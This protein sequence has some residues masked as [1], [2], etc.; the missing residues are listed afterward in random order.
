[1]AFSREARGQETA[2]R[3]EWNIHR[4]RPAREA[5]PM[6]I[7]EI[8]ASRAA[9]NAS[10][11]PESESSS[12]PPRRPERPPL[13]VPD[14]KSERLS[15]AASRVTAMTRR[16]SRSFGRLGGS[17]A[18][19][20][21]RE[22]EHRTRTG[23]ST[24]IGSSIR[25]RKFLMPGLRRSERETFTGIGT[26]ER[27]T[28]PEKTAPRVREPRIFRMGPEARFPEFREGFIPDV[29][30]RARVLGIAGERLP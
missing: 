20:V 12:G 21:Q 8:S 7:A 17:W 28:T 2:A 3:M 13:C 15:S 14:P 23:S 26:E 10:D 27:G 24:R 9:V 5:S 30:G 11:V 25:M 1:M 19:S 18:A 6:G 4:T 29:P 22:L 16:I